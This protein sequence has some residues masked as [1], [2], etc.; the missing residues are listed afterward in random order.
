MQTRL[1]NA[2]TIQCGLAVLVTTFLVTLIGGCS[3]LCS[4]VKLAKIDEVV[5]APPAKE[6]VKETET[7]TATILG[8]D[9]NGW[10]LKFDANHGC[11]AISSMPRVERKGTERQ[12]DAI[13]LT[14]AGVDTAAGVGLLG[15]TWFVLSKTQGLSQEATVTALALGATPAAVGLSSFA[16]AAFTMNSR[17]PDGEGV[18]EKAIDPKITRLPQPCSGPEGSVQV[19]WW[20]DVNGSAAQTRTVKLGEPVKISADDVRGLIS[21]NSTTIRVELAPT[22]P[23]P[24]VAFVAAQS[25]LSVADVSSL[26]AWQA[27]ERAHIAQAKREEE[28]AEAKEQ[29]AREAERTARAA[30]DERSRYLALIESCVKDD[31]GA[32]FK[33][34]CTVAGKLSSAECVRSRQVVLE[35]AVPL[36]PKE[37]AAAEDVVAHGLHTTKASKEILNSMRA[38]KQCLVSLVVTENA[39]TTLYEKLVGDEAQERQRQVRRA[40]ESANEYFGQQA[41][42]AQ[43]C[44]YNDPDTANGEIGRQFVSCTTSIDQAKYSADK[45]NCFS[46]QVTPNDKA[47]CVD[48]VNTQ[49]VQELSAC[50]QTCWSMSDACGVAKSVSY[51]AGHF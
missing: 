27:S 40:R 26:V 48:R 35:K 15:A 41:A 8:A 45:E 11:E 47:L 16:W 25:S 9:A 18:K 46:S 38:D 4:S 30:A 20:G 43:S 31:V 7:A 1:R 39:F 13:G 2:T 22:S 33:T 28:L 32:R 6:T 49:E 10:T 23:R 19:R 34:W 42:R 17:L 29:T 3:L 50:R 51:C 24:D 14:A 21:A 44:P 12:L 5:D 36:S 37:K